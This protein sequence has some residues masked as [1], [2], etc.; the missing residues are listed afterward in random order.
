MSTPST[1]AR[2]DAARP[3]SRSGH[4]AGGDGSNGGGRSVGRLAGGSRRRGGLL[5]PELTSL[6]DVLTILLVFLM[7][8]F[9]TDASSTVLPGLALPLSTSRE[10]VRSE[11]AVQVT[12]TAVF[13]DG[14]WVADLSASGDE[15]S[16]PAL[17]RALEATRN[18]PAGAPGPA[19]PTESPRS[20][21]SAELVG[22]P[23]PVGLAETAGPLSV[24]C[25]RGQTFAVLQRVL[26]AC[27]EAGFAD[28]A[29]VVRREE[30]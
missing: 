10:T 14:R 8:S 15:A 2:I 23:R 9:S 6:V 13:L 1:H 19:E 11:R 17:R 20:A 27:S 22:P 7:K 12:N 18:A 24:Q 28:L 3:G 30:G 16:L 21:E 26:R 4:G 5:R 29:I 25:D